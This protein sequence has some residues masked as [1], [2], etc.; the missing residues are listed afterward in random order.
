M[1]PLRQSCNTFQEAGKSVLKAAALLETVN[2]QRVI[3]SEIQLH[4]SAHL[5][6]IKKKASET[7]PL[8]FRLEREKAC[9]A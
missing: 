8:N 1:R 5:Y 2:E 9:L 6:S 7:F 3:L 4:F